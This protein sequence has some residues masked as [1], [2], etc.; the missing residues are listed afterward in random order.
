MSLVPTWGRAGHA[1]LSFDHGAEPVGRGCNEQTVHFKIRMPIVL[2]V[3]IYS[4]RHAGYISGSGQYNF[5]IPLGSE[6]FRVLC[7]QYTTVQYCT[8]MPSYP[9]ILDNLGQGPMAL[10]FTFGNTCTQCQY[11][12]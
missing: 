5:K 2:P 8:D 1:V 7:G 6:A 10:G 12:L 11:S 9:I 4:H 3:S